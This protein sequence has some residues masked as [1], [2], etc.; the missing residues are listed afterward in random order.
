MVLKFHNEPLARALWRED[1]NGETW[2]FMYALAEVR[3][4]SIPYEEMSRIIGYKPAHNYQGFTVLDEEKSERVLEALGLYSEKLTPPVSPESFRTAATRPPS[5]LDRE[6]TTSQRTESKY[7][8]D[9]LFPD[10]TARC[11]L[12]GEE[13]PRE[14]FIGAHIKKRAACTDDEKLDIPNVVMGACV[15]GCD[16]LYEKGYVTVGDD[17][18]LQVAPGTGSAE[19]DARLARLAGRT[20]PDQDDGRRQYTEW[21]RANV[22]RG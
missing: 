22:F 10:A 4:L 13:M 5:E 2:E 17:W 12:C 18:T 7:V 9:I 8:R 20:F 14:F 16:A 19:I 15:F 21:H 6:R 1:K 11:D 3:S